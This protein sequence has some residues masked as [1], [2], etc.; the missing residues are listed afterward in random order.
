MVDF[1][2][3]DILGLVKDLRDLFSS[4]KASMRPSPVQN[5][6]AS[7]SNIPA[8]MGQYQSPLRGAWKNSGDFSLTRAT[9]IHHPHGH[10]GVDMRISGG[11]EVFP[12][13]PGRVLN[14]GPSVGGAKGGNAVVI[15][16]DNG[17]KTYY[18][19]LG[20]ISVHRGDEVGMDTVIGTVG[21]SGD[22]RTYGAWPHVHFQ[23]WVN[24]Q[25]TNPGQFF[26]V[27]KY[28]N[29]TPDEHQW[30]PGAKEV[31][32]Q[33]SAQEHQQERRAAFSF[34]V[35][36]LNEVCGRYLRLTK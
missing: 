18:A 32:D 22:A 26:S 17:I 28:S 5:Q 27:P 2:A 20:T 30:L 4:Q 13:A 21:D 10:P 14:V 3:S 36:R 11:T 29:P 7:P 16:H 1:D 35:D 15:Q 8:S 31:A 24:G 33:W 34:G 6:P 12:M 9:D 25:L 19:H 23:V